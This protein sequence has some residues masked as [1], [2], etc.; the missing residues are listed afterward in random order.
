MDWLIREQEKK[1]PAQPA[2][3]EEEEE[4]STVEL[5]DD[6]PIAADP[7]QAPTVSVPAAAE[8]AVP[9]VEAVARS[10]RCEECS[11]LH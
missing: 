4:R 1:A 10:L 8:S 5:I 6:E 11:D 7:V 3:D 9:P 2:P